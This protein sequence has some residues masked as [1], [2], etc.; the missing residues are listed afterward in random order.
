M[1]A[2]F[3]S[4]NKSVNNDSEAL[5][6]WNHLIFMVAGNVGNAFTL[7]P[8]DGTLHVARELDI[9]SMTEYMLI[10]KASDKGSPP[11]SSTIPVH[12]MVVMA[13]NAP[14]R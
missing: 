9:G 6:P 2:R 14:P 5:M 4:I 10:V 3:I 1:S 12:I 13:D 11:L 7:D 8:V